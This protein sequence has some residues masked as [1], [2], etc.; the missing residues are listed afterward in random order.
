MEDVIETMN[1]VEI[2]VKEEEELFFYLF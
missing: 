1:N 2:V